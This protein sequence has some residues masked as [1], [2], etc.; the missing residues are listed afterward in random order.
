MCEKILS[1]I[2]NTLNKNTTETYLVLSFWSNLYSEYEEALLF[3]FKY[4][5]H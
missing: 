4:D 2:N 1:E 5:I 3:L